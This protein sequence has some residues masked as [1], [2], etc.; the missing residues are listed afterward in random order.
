MTQT[1]IL[2][3][4]I[5]FIFVFI[6]SCL[7]GYFSGIITALIYRFTDF[8]KK[9]TLLNVGIYISTVYLPYL[10]SDALQLS[11]IVTILFTGIASRRYIN[12]NISRDAVKM[13]SFVFKLLANVSETA[14]F[15][16]LGLS[17]FS[18]PK[19]SFKLGFIGITLFLC[20][21]ARA[22][23]VYPLLSL[24][25][26]SKLVSRLI[27]N[28]RT[29]D[30]IDLLRDQNLEKNDFITMK[31]MHAV[32]FAG[33][34]GTVA[35][36]CCLNFPTENRNLVICTTTV[37]ILWTLF[38]QG[39]LTEPFLKCLGIPINVDTKQLEIEYKDQDFERK[40]IYP[41]VIREFN[42]GNYRNKSNKN[43][44]DI[45]SGGGS[46]IDSV[47]LGRDDNDD[48]SIEGK[49]IESSSFSKPRRNRPK[50]SP[51]TAELEEE[52]YHLTRENLEEIVDGNYEDK[53]PYDY[54]KY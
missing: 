45:S 21:I 47:R 19:A 39:S 4:I 44:M 25:N 11:G 23:H 15:T 54:G 35:F 12:K 16:F 26:L 53:D 33:L 34:R 29:L 2:Q 32:F 31:T 10:L 37:I 8:N 14:C 38:V 52:L 43:D 13:S 40:Y 42:D 24:V 46:L 48:Q 22:V 30:R 3:S 9:Q 28:R 41:L 27:Q 36:A 20:Y 51:M 1:Q 50:L 18:L 7:I 5:T 49:S 6:S 17:V